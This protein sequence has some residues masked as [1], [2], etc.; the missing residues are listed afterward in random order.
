MNVGRH[1]DRNIHP[2]EAG[3]GKQEMEEGVWAADSGVVSVKWQDSSEALWRPEW[4]VH[5][6]KHDLYSPPLLVP[7]S[8][9]SETSAMWSTHRHRRVTH[10]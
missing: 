2:C 3:A 10:L 6:E 9:T 4:A 7:V 8:L 1:V 5:G